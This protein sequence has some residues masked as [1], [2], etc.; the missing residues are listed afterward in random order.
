M[1]AEAAAA[2]PAWLVVVDMQRVFGDA[3]S[4]WAMPA[5]ADVVPA[6]NALVER[7]EGRTVFTR[8]VPPETPAG[9][10][11]DYYARW[12]FALTPA[13]APFW[14]LVPE[15]P[16]RGAAVIGAPT[17]SKW[18]PALRDALGG[19]RD[20]VVCGVATDCCV[21]STT[22]AAIDDGARVRV[23]A[24]ACAALSP[25]SQK[26]SLAALALYGPQVRVVTADQLGQP[27]DPLS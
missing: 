6:V 21:L 4:P 24:D 18:V 12:P 19:S 2:D 5:F 8:F 14:E 1:T 11:Q 3:D 22:L 9:S 16:T 7:F 13:A 15:V 23:V 17:M 26:R 27:H 10:W 20:L 25:E